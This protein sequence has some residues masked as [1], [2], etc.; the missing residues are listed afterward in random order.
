MFIP[1]KNMKG[2]RTPY[3]VSM[4]NNVSEEKTSVYFIGLILILKDKIIDTSMS[5]TKGNAD[6]ICS[7]GNE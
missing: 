1:S 5:K 3:K 4:Q 2:I 6:S 7:R